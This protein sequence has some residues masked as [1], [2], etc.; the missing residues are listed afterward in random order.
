MNLSELLRGI[1]YQT[2]LAD[3][4]ISD[5]CSDSR[6]ITPGCIFVCIKGEKFD[7]HSHAKKA[8][9]AGAAALSASTRWGFP[10][11]LS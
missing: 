10:V 1:T 6:K 11:R 2:S 3:R 8:V 5:V 9:E 4:E 7:G